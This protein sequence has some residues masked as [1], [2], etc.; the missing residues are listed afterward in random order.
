M[1]IQPKF[2]ADPLNSNPNLAEAGSVILDVNNR[3]VAI[4]RSKIKDIAKGLAEIAF[5]M[6]ETN[7][8][9]TYTAMMAEDIFEALQ[10]VRKRQKEKKKKGHS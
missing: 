5:S 7:D 6:G 3:K 9:D 10:K 2:N 8:M 1:N 4:R